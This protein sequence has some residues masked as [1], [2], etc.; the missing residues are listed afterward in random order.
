M[1]QVPP[2]PAADRP[3]PQCGP[4]LARSG[5]LR[6]AFGLLGFALA[7]SGRRSGNT[8]RNAAQRPA[9]K[10][11]NCSNFFVFGTLGNVRPFLETA[12]EP[13]RVAV[14]LLWDFA[15]LATFL[16]DF[17]FLGPH[18][19]RAGGR[20]LYGKHFR[21]KITFIYRWLVLSRTWWCRKPISASRHFS[22]GF[23]SRA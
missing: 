22:L 13:R 9:G 6:H 18:F 19:G 5:R 1:T 17:R 21:T 2:A 20:P 23:A 10:I 14:E 11:S 4:W 7:R 8:P 15:V 12:R 3:R 16:G